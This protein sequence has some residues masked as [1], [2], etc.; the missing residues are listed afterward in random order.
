MLSIYSRVRLGSFED[1][2][3]ARAVINH[4]LFLSF[5]LATTLS[6]LTCISILR[7][8]GTYQRYDGMIL[9]TKYTA[10]VMQYKDSVYQYQ[11]IKCSPIFTIIR[12]LVAVDIKFVTEWNTGF[13]FGPCR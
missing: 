2:Q 8:S 10:R 3:Q 7:N 12:G 6:Y 11:Y 5:S 4:S 9:M 1:G 13:T